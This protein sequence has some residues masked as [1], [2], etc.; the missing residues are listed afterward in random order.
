MLL[1]EWNGVLELSAVL[2]PREPV[3][4]LRLTIPVVLIIYTREHPTSCRRALT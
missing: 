3:V 4:D 1:S 2:K